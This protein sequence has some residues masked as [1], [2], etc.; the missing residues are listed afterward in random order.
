MVEAPRPAPN[1]RRDRRE[2]WVVIR[3]STFRFFVAT[4][5]SPTRGAR[6]NMLRPPRQC[7][8]R[9][10]VG[11]NCRVELLRSR[12]PAEKKLFPAALGLDGIPDFRSDIR[13]TEPR[14]GANARGRS[15]IDLGQI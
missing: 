1:A 13:P 5:A 7:G 2:S 3:S 9:N 10:Q 8:K 14:N 6:I 11:E 12:Q 15:D 4:A